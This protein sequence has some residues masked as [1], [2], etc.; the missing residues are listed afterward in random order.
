[1]KAQIWP[2]PS[3]HPP[4]GCTVLCFYIIASWH[5]AALASPHEGLAVGAADR[6]RA[7]CDWGL[8]S[9]SSDNCHGRSQSQLPEAQVPQRMAW[10]AVFKTPL[11]EL[12][13]NWGST[14]HFHIYFQIWKRN[15]Q[16]RM[17]NRPIF[18]ISAGL[19][20]QTS[21]RTHWC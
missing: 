9:I 12:G 5:L 17:D 14:A 21:A 18:E 4:C 15:V 10:P 19:G 13:S 2:A 1:M 6:D 8:T 3:W 16:R 11:L 20:E 7:T